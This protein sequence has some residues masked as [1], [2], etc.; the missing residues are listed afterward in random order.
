MHT[1]ADNGLTPTQIS[2][3][4]RNRAAAWVAQQI[5]PTAALS[6]DPVM[7]RALKAHGVSPG[8]LHPVAPNA[9][10]LPGSQIVVATPTVRKQFGSSLTSVYAP[11]VLAS[12]GS[13]N[14][15]IDIR[16]IAP[17]GASAFMSQFRADQQL[18]KKNS[19]ALLTPGLMALSRSAQIQLASGQVDTRLMVL[20][21]SLALYHI[22][23]IAFGDSGPGATT[24]M[25]LRSATL[26]G[27]KAGLQSLLRYVRAQ[28][29]APYLPQYTQ[30]V[31]RGRKTE[32]VI[33]FSAPSPLGLF[34]ASP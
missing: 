4:T 34:D 3:A 26:T 13:G 27:S 32:L 21:S 6:C 25:P 8:D 14:V 33:E 5:S 31:Q 16:L 20:L 17:H 22:D 19:A 2:A 15:R 23:V 1:S 12:F 7:C 9:S 29:I 30:L 24:G 10:T 11:M 18:R 28:E